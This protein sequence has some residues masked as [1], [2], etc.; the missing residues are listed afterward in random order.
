MIFRYL[1]AGFA[2]FV[3]GFQPEARKE[4][5]DQIDFP[6]VAGLD[7]ERENLGRTQGYERLV[8]PLPER[9][10][11]IQFREKIGS[12]LVDFLSCNVHVFEGGFVSVIVCQSELDGSI[13]RE[14]LRKGVPGILP[15]A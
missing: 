3:L 6:P 15:E 12:S 1:L 9:I 14:R 7:R 13:F 11:A 5:L 10:G 2:R 4:R 8:R